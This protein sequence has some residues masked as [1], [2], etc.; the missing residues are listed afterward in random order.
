MVSMSLARLSAMIPEGR[1]NAAEEGCRM[2]FLCTSRTFS[3]QEEESKRLPKGLEASMARFFRVV[4][5][6]DVLA[7]IQKVEKPLGM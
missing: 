1:R 6:F 5:D 3:N 7:T 4:C 2:P